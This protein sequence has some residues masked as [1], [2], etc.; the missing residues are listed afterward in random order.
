[1]KKYLFLLFISI[2][3]CVFALQLS[4]SNVYADNKASIV[5]TGNLNEHKETEVPHDEI[6]DQ[7]ESLKEEKTVLKKKG[8]LPKTGETRLIILSTMG[9]IFIIL[10]GYVFY[11]YKLKNK[12]ILKEFTTEKIN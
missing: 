7:T 9:I 4:E 5:I 1:M 3:S 8:R 2:V 12:S 6:S 11:K 10:S